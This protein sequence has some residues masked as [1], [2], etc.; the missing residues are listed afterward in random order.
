MN[1]WCVLPEAF[2]SNMHDACSLPP[3]FGYNMPFHL[4]AAGF[5]T[6]STGTSLCWRCWGGEQGK[7][8]CKGKK[9]R[10]GPGRPKGK[11][12]AKAKAK[13][14]KAK[15]KGKGVKD[16]DEYDDQVE[17]EE[18]EPQEEEQ[19]DEEAKEDE[20]A[21]EEEQKDEEAKEEEQKDEEA[22]EEEPKKPVVPKAKAKGKAAKAK[23]TRD[24]KKRQ[25]EAEQVEGEGGENTSKGNQDE[26]AGVIPARKRC[27]GEAAT[28]A[29]RTEPTSSIGRLKWHALREAFGQVIKPTL[30]AYSKAEE[31]CLGKFGKV[32]GFLNVDLQSLDYPTSQHRVW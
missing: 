4:L 3:F 23:A 15:G 17:D 20:E 13:G 29:K 22:K 30:A 9:Q 12:K 28:F 27:K 5:A 2:L 21:N 18:E 32:F 1:I 31:P 26:G 8:K 10:K 24:S 25:V 11:G 19:K 14:S 7:G 16:G 6:F